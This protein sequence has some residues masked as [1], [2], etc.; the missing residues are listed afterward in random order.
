MRIDEE[1]LRKHVSF[2]SRLKPLAMQ[3]RALS[4]KKK[5]DTESIA[6]LTEFP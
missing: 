4:V 3:S 1:S 6:S 2:L 5:F